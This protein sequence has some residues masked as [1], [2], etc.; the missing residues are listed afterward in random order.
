MQTLVDIV[1][2][3]SPIVGNAL[4]GPIGGVIAALLSHVFGA[5]DLTTLGTN[6][7]NDP[8]AQIKLK[9]IEEKIQSN[10]LGEIQS[11]RARDEKMVELA[12]NPNAN[13]VVSFIALV[14]HLL[15]FLV[16]AAILIIPFVSMFFI[17]KPNYT[18]LTFMVGNLLIIFSK[19]CNMYFGNV[20]DNG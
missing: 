20:K 19:G 12:A 11:A 2:K 8:D 13:L 1:Q 6:I 5:K 17:D 18:L 16:G 10:V 14:P 4:G 3:L 7:Q 15:V 9:E